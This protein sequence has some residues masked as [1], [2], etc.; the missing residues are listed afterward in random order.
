MRRGILVQQK[1]LQRFE[2]Q[3]CLGPTFQT[4][5]KATLVRN[6]QPDLRRKKRPA[7]VTAFPPYMCSLLGT[8][9]G[10]GGGMC[11]WPKSHSPRIE[12]PGSRDLAESQE[13]LP[14]QSIDPLG[15]LGSWAEVAASCHCGLATQPGAGLR[16]LPTQPPDL[17]WPSEFLNHMPTAP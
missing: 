6:A 1:C 13:S 9:Q 5:C 17:V 14:C 2:G 11:G 10:L 7:V 8:W 4:G 3:V 15:T 12:E 16:T